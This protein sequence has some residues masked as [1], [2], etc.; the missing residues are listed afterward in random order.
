M[1]MPMIQK[2][3]EFAEGLA[4]AEKAGRIKVSESRVW[5]VRRG[6]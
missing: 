2:L 4:Y 5:L 3:A 1:G 6:E